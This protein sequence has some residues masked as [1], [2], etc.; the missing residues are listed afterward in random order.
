MNYAL[1]WLKIKIVTTARALKWRH[2][3]R[4]QN[5][6]NNNLIFRNTFHALIFEASE[7]VSYRKILIWCPISWKSW[8]FAVRICMEILR[9]SKFTPFTGVTSDTTTGLVSHQQYICWLQKSRGESVNYFDTRL[10]RKKS[11]KNLNLF[12]NI[13]EIFEIF[14]I[15]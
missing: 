10:Q 3:T 12:L 8:N 13:F 14:E 4:R 7:P 11:D 5:G 15:F 2:S 9:L 6:Q 1:H